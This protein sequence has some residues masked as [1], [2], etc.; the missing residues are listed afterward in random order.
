MLYC[1][2]S[3]DHPR[4][5]SEGR[6][7]SLAMRHAIAEAFIAGSIESIQTVAYVAIANMLIPLSC[8]FQGH[9]RTDFAPHERGCL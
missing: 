4:G 1:G 3:N 5:G 6:P 7:I 9:I 8:I 2:R